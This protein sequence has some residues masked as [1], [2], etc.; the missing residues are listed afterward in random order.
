MTQP[1]IPDLKDPI[2][3]GIA[4][5]RAELM[6]MR[7]ELEKQIKAIDKSI[8]LLGQAVQVFDPSTR[9]HL[10]AHS[11]K[12]KRHPKTRRFVLDILREAEGPLAVRQIAAAWMASEGEAESHENLRLYRGRVSSCLQNCRAQG[13]A[14]CER[15]PEGE[16][17]WSLTDNA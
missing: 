8:A 2:A 10:A 12:P 5:K 6:A 7:R 1:L 14:T 9:L 17:V 16:P 4:K 13:L 3:I 15:V 11:L